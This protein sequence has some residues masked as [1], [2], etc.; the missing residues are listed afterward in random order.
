MKRFTLLS[1]LAW[2][3]LAASAQNVGVGTASPGTKLDVNGA[4]TL[5]EGSLL[6]STGATTGVIPTGYSQVLVTG[7]PGGAFNLT[8]PTTPTN[9]GQHLIIYNNTTSGYAGT[10][11][12]T[13]IPNG[14]AIEFIYSA[15]NWVATS[16][17]ASG[18]GSYVQNTTTTQPSS[19]FNISGN[20]TIGGNENV[21]GT[22]THTGAATFGSTL[23][24]TGVTT[25]SNLAPTAGV[26]LNSAAGVLSSTAGALPVGNGGTGTA[27][28][29]SGYVKGGSPMTAVT[30]IPGAD[31]NGNI[32]GNAANVTGTVPPANGGTG[33]AN[34]NAA[35][36]T[37]SGNYAYTRTLTGTTN[38]TLPTSG[39]LY[40]TATGSI[41][42]SQL[43]TSLT[44]E[45]GSGAA[46]FGTSPSLAT[47]SLAGEVFSTNAAVSAA[48]TTLATAAALTS[49]YN[50]ITTAA[51][52]SGVALPTA[53]VGR[54]I[55]IVNKGAN[56]VNVYPAAVVG[57]S[58]DALAANTAI[59]IPVNGWME[60]NASSTT[61]W[62]SSSNISFTSGSAVTSFTAGTTGLTPSSATTGAVTLAG[63]LNTA[64]G[65]TG[66]NNA[67]TLTNASNTTITGGGTLALGGF[68]L[69]VPAT[70]TAALGAGTNGYNAYWNGTNTLA[71]EQYTNVTRGGTGVGTLASNG[72]LYGNG[73]GVVQ[74]TAASTAAGQILQTA[75][76]GGVPSWATPSSIAVTSITSASPLTANTNA[77]GAVTVNLTGVVP[78]ANGGTGINNGS[79][80]LTIPASGTAALG[81]GTTNYAAYWSGANTVAAEQYLATSR[82]GMGASMTAGAIG[83]IPY[84]TSTTA[85]GTLADVAAGSYLRSGGA[86][87][88]PLWSTLTLPNAATTGDILYASGT[89]TIGNLAAVAAG[90]VLTSNGTGAAP[91]WSS[92]NG[93]NWTLKGNGSI[94]QPAVPTTYG[95]STFGSTENF[96]GNT[97]AK[98]LTFG[99]TN[100]ERMRILS[101]GNVGIGTAAPGSP[102]TVRTATATANARTASLGNAIGDPLFELAVSRGATTNSA[103]DV[104]TQIGQAYNGG[105]ISEGIKFI[106]NSSATNGAMAFMTNAGAERMRID[107]A[108]N[109]GIQQTSPSTQLHV[110][111]INNS[112]SSY[113]TFS[114]G[115]NAQ[116]RSW[117][118]GVPYGGATTSSPNYG[119]TITDMGNSTTPPFMIDFNTHYV[120]IGQ[121]APTGILD[122]KNSDY[123]SGP[124]VIE[125]AVA[126]N[127][128]TTI[129]FTNTNS[130]AHTYDIIGSTGAGANMGAGYFG[131]YDVTSAAYRM[132]INSLG[133][134]GAGIQSP[135]S[136]FHLYATG[137]TGKQMLIDGPG[138]SVAAGVSEP[139]L[140][141]ADNG[142]LK[143]SMVLAN[144]A[145]QW[146]SDAAID[147]LVIRPA[148]N[149]SH[150]L[151]NENGGS[152]S[153]MSIANGGV[154]FGQSSPSYPIE[155]NSSTGWTGYNR[156]YN[157]TYLLSWSGWSSS[158]TNVGIYCHPSIATDN[159]FVSVSDRRTKKDMAISHSDNDLSVLKKIEITDYKFIDTLGKGTR[160]FK[161]VIAQQVEAVYPQA[162]STIKGII[163]NIYAPA[164]QVLKDGKYITLVMD[165][166]HGLREGDKVSI[167]DGAW[168]QEEKEVC[169]TDEKTFTVEIENAKD[170]YFVY[171]KVI[172][173]LKS[174]D[175]DAISMLNVSATQELAKKLAGAEEHIQLLQAQN[176]TF[177]QENKS[178]KATTVQQSDL[179]KT[180]KAQIDAINER[181]NTTT[182]K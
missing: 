16:T 34:N 79:N 70:G 173:D 129:S 89:N 158:S 47:P 181:L 74:V 68:T 26:V 84:A 174:V 130:G 37:S 154:G 99:T 62:Y 171:G 168:N 119:F 106:R 31:V 52:S 6:I 3:V 18:S 105:T 55:V 177:K 88:A 76:S 71:G 21:T 61:Q 90:S 111:N 180:M 149:S 49:D 135:T 141:F 108:G 39:T 122:I 124:M 131:I 41:T 29:L 35:T 86:G 179:M 69:T 134:V 162:V 9:A 13:A 136:P 67:G 51:A 11:A 163:P 167:Y 107:N 146:S 96:L 1:V 125:D 126:N 150:I 133:Y 143:W 159:Y 42:S 97:D 94:S 164:K 182:S 95:T 127:V 113:M 166:T 114:A 57:S 15:G 116:Y 169:Y 48:G 112:A 82:G 36:V 12:G 20:G 32:S 104:T 45:T 60:F 7:S 17:A 165:K 30:T 123:S 176:E 33:I 53:T 73:T 152:G 93:L 175:Y 50:V 120:G 8:G 91:V 78:S 80:T 63:I 23:G 102:L 40:G 56:A 22:S 81:T 103:G 157:T 72:I 28:A 66:V 54:K 75:V 118:I 117:Q 77:T 148:S 100:L 27:S 121:T 10:F 5:R 43:S 161:K 98:D 59:S 83:A 44:D 139:S 128:G 138:S 19:N 156:W 85:Y 155:V 178:L 172:D 115:N 58:I 14:I 24:V 153:V 65:G 87:A 137:N 110:G 151:F 46:V 92:N 144:A 64:N 142:T 145:G 109:V 147:D 4:L 132:V 160:P 2:L 25:L 38:V 170:E 101:S 140:G